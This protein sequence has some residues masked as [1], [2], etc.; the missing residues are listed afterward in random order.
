M[1]LNFTSSSFSGFLDD[2]SC[3]NT[4]KES[5]MVEVSSGRIMAGRAREPDCWRDLRAALLS[6]SMSTERESWLFIDVMV[7]LLF[8]VLLGGVEGD[9]KADITCLCCNL[10]CIALHCCNTV[11]LVQLQ[12]HLMD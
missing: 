4:T 11:Y 7:Y 8:C 9:A 10:L 12:S 3:H 1:Q 2:I 5:G 6:S